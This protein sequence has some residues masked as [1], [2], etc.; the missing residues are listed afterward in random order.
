MNRA[1]LINGHAQIIDGNQS[2]LILMTA[3][4]DYYGRIQSSKL[5]VNKA[6]VNC[7]RIAYE[8]QILLLHLRCTPDRI[9]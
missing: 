2:V 5:P 1:N 7:Y 4:D 9:G 6:T 3:P 8:P